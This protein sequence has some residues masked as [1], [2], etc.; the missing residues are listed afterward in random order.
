MLIHLTFEEMYL[1]FLIHRSGTIS[2]VKELS[3]L[4]GIPQFRVS[5][6]LQR[7]EKKKLIEIRAKK[8]NMLNLT[9][10]PDADAILNDLETAHTDFNATRFKDFTK[11]EQELYLSLSNRMDENI[12]EAL[13][14]LY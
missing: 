9:L 7:L 4:S 2:N 3:D 1:I 13:W 6:A 11:E 10:L 14:K 12:Q 8:R 5:K